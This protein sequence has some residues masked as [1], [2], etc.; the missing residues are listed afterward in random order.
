MNISVA[1]QLLLYFLCWFQLPFLSLW[2]HLEYF[3][4]TH[5]DQGLNF[6]TETLGVKVATSR[7]RLDCNPQSVNVETEKKDCTSESLKFK[8][9][10]ETVF[11]N[12]S[13]LRLRLKLKRLVNY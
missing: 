10:I 12:A 6:V 3:Q 5:H 2:A 13:V 11:L 4:G 9:D 7:I 1:N 8:T